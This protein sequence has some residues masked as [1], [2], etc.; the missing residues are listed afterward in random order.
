MRMVNLFIM[1]IDSASILCIHTNPTSTQIVWIKTA[2][3]SIH[4]ES[5]QTHIVN[6][7]EGSIEYTAFTYTLRSKQNRPVTFYTTNKFTWN[8]PTSAHMYT[9][10]SYIEKNQT[11]CFDKETM[12]AEE[13]NSHTHPQAHRQLPCP[14]SHK[15]PRSLVHPQPLT[16][17]FGGCCC[18]CCRWALDST[19][20]CRVLRK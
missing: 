20:R 7:Q 19:L 2:R 16:Y 11:S 13:S 18:C 8:Q 9:Y 10:H 4:S 6:N 5:A 1:S 17:R 15:L 14:P 3:R 12:S